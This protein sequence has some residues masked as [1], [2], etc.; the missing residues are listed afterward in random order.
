MDSDPARRNVLGVLEKFPDIA[1]DG[2]ALRKFGQEVISGLAKERIH[3]SW[4]VPGGVNAPLQPAVRDKILAGLPEAKAIVRRTLKFFKGVL[5]QFKEEIEN[6]GNAPSMYAG[7]VDAAGK[8][9]LYDGGIRFKDA[10]GKIVA[11]HVPASDYQKFIGEASPYQFILE[12]ALL[13]AHRFPGRR[14]PRRTSGAAERRQELRNAPGRCGVRRIP[15]A[16]GKDRAQLFPFPLCP[17][18]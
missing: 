4:T 5:D 2:I 8:L 3:P 10:E 13:Q 11:D 18:D 7:L 15:P 14:L 17:A 9:Q 1:R 16:L 12:G 6:F